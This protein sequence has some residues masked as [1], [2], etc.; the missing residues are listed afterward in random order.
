MISAKLLMARATYN[1]KD[2]KLFGIVKIP[3]KISITS[4]LLNID[5][6]FLLRIRPIVKILKCSKSLLSGDIL[7]VQIR[8]GENL[9]VQQI[10]ALN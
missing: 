3:L 8:P 7:K 6:S 9:K 2:I 10:I 5:A 1:D 4:L